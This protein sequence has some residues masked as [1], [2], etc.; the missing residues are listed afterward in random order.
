MYIYLCQFVPKFA[1]S[2]YRTEEHKKTEEQTERYKLD[3]NMLIFSQN[4]PTR[5]AV[6][7]FDNNYVPPV[8]PISLVL[9]MAVPPVVI[10]Q[11]IRQ[12]P[13]VPVS[14][15][16]QRPLLPMARMISPQ[17]V[18]QLLLNT[19]ENEQPEPVIMPRRSTAKTLFSSFGMMTR[20]APNSSGSCGCGMRG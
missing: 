7:F 20:A 15:P 13:V 16:K 19:E 3:R 12:L 10:T 8:L 18:S 17:E 1:N 14:V 4:I 5:G 11:Q 2:I 6:H 9:P